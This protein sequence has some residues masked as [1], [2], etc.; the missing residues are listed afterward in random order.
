M[1]SMRS[2]VG[3][4]PTG[5]SGGEKRC[6]REPEPYPTIESYVQYNVLIPIVSPKVVHM[7]IH[8]DQN[9]ILCRIG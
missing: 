5:Q 8:S 7:H 4:G 2:G 3:L 6:K 1:S 9:G